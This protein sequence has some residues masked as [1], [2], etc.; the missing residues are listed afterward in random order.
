[1]MLHYIFYMFCGFKKGYFIVFFYLQMRAKCGPNICML[2]DG[3]KAVSQCQTVFSYHPPLLW[4]R[5]GHIQ[6]II[7]AKMGRMIPKFPEGERFHYTMPDGATTS[8][9]VY[10]PHEKGKEGRGLICFLFCYYILILKEHVI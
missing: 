10:D 9:D 3:H 2:L 7:Y 8:F 4:G 1:M 6:T 5:S